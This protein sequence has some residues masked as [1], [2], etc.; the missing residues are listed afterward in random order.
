VKASAALRHSEPGD[1]GSMSE[2]PALKT[3]R[4][5][6]AQAESAFASADGLFHLEEGLGLLDELNEG[7]DA[8]QRKMAQTLAATYATKIFGRIRGAIEA[9]RAIPP[10]LLEH[11][12]KLMLAFDQGDFA[13]PDAARALKIAV[14][15]RLIDLAYE[16]Y[17]AAAKRQALERFGAI[18]DDTK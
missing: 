6:L 15:R 13:L 1:I 8:A 18:V 16:G 11:Y 14:A 5:H 7:D 4:N 17:P 2:S 3:A 9:D 10:P 12:F